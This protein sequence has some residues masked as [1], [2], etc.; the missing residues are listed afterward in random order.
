MP[1][2]NSNDYER[3]RTTN[4]VWYLCLPWMDKYLKKIPTRNYFQR[5]IREYCEDRGITRQSI[6]L[7][8]GAR[9]SMFFDGEWKSVSF[10]AIKDLAAQGTDILFVEKADICEILTPFARKFGIALVNTIGFL[11]EYGQ[12]LMKEAKKS[13]ANIA[14]LTDYEDYGYSIVSQV[15]E[16]VKIPRIGIDEDTFRYFGLDRNQKNLSVPSKGRIKDFNF[17]DNF[18]NVDKTFLRKRRVEIDAVLAVVGNERFWGFIEH[19]LTQLYP[20]RNANRAVAI[21]A[22][23]TLYMEGWQDLLTFMNE[24]YTG[25]VEDKVKEIQGHLS[26]IKGIVDVEEKTEEIQDEL[27][28]LVDADEGVKLMTPM[29]KKLLD[30]LKARKKSS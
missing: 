1:I 13:M 22:V 25:L 2:S 10:D 11:T 15:L 9:A 29:I 18:E 20:T 8:S 16:H 21:P 24:Y 23:E 3:V 27:Q 4:S 6:G 17:L 26:N 7:V 28:E 14:I 19:K 12:E 30:Q 5:L